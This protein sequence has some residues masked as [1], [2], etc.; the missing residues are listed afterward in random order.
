MLELPLWRHY[1]IMSK[2][3]HRR[4]ASLAQEEDDAGFAGAVVQA[5]NL[6]LLTSSQL[7]VMGGG[8]VG[9]ACIM[10]SGCPRCMFV[11]SQLLLLHLTVDSPA[12]HRT[13]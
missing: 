7:Q 5:L 9:H 10:A 12:L 8:A 13:W 6:I 11:T 3:S 2:Y 4:R 1:H